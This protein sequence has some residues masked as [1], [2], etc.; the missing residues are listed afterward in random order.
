MTPK[1]VTVLLG[2]CPVTSIPLPLNI[3]ILPAESGS[4]AG[5]PLSVTI[6][7]IDEKVPANSTKPSVTVKC[8]LSNDE[9]PLVANKPVAAA[10]EFMPVT[11]TVLPAPDV[12]IPFVPAIS[13]TFPIGIAVPASVKKLV[14]I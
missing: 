4:T 14:G 6:L 13:K 11:V 5:A 7:S 3:F 10:V 1:I 9:T 8:E 12:V 2:P